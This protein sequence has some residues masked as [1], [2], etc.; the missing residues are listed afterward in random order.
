MPRGSVRACAAGICGGKRGKSAAAV[1][2]EAAAEKEETCCLLLR[3][4]FSGVGVAINITFVGVVVAGVL[5]VG[6]MEE[7]EEMKKKAK[8]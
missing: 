4:S 3:G 8:A 6:V 1:R 2:K 7:G 5:V